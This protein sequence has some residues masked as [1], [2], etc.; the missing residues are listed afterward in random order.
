[1]VDCAIPRLVL[2]A[3]IY[4]NVKSQTFKIDCHN[5]LAI[6]CNG[7]TFHEYEL[8]FC[9][10]ILYESPHCQLY[11]RGVSITSS[12]PITEFF[13]QKS[14]KKKNLSKNL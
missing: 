8:S 4:I 11:F 7:K 9:N 13:S 12:M 6:N 3:L 10:S 5:L 1:M 14:Q 2:Y